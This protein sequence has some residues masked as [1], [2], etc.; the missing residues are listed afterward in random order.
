MSNVVQASS[1]A[2]M[3]VLK[4]LQEWGIE[5]FLKHAQESANFYKR[6]R[7]VMAAALDRHLTGLADWTSPDAAMF[8]WIKLR[9]SPKTSDSLEIQNAEIDGDS[10]TFIRNKAM[11][12]G[13]LV[14]PGATSYV[15]G[16]STARVR[17]CFSMLSDEAT[18]EAIRRLAVVLRDQ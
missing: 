17:V 15:D 5:G 8:F 11:A 9:L 1:V 3:L 12:G 4:V 14:L 6:R 7:D 10:T 18:D 16:R 2:Q 13:V